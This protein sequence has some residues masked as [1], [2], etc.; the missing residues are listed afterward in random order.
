MSAILSK[1]LPLVSL[2]NVSV[3]FEKVTNNFICKC[4]PDSKRIRTV[5]FVN[6]SETHEK[7]TNSVTS[8][9]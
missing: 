1:R 9:C 6:V 5:S 3:T 4:Q 8:E 7:H 2:A